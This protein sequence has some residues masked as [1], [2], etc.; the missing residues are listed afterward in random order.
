MTLSLWDLALYASGVFVLFITPGPVWMAIIARS[1]SGGIRSAAPLAL[2]VV[3]G[4]M[5]W[6]VLAILGVSWIVS[7]F[8]T[9]QLALKGLAVAMFLWLGIQII[10]HAARRVAADSRL[11]RPGLWSGFWAG[12]LVILGNPK[13]ILFYMGLL[14]G[15]FNLTRLSGWDIAAIVAVSQIV[16]LVG[17]LVLAGA[18]DR[19]RTVLGSARALRRTNLVAGWLLIAVACAIPFT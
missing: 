2:G 10:R 12:V 17:N 18:V 8:A 1:L 6:P 9:V 19:L 11:T 5:L 15:F 14:P 7:A 13:A 3:V 16:P 4:D